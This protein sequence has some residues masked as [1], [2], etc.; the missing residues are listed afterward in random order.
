M[1]MSSDAIDAYSIAVLAGAPYAQLLSQSLITWPLVFVLFTLPAANLLINLGYVSGAG[2]VL[3]FARIAPI[4]SGIG[5]ALTWL[6]GERLFIRSLTAAQNLIYIVASMRRR[7]DW[8]TDCNHSYNDRLCTELFRINVSHG[9]AQHQSDNNWPAQQFNKYGVRQLPHYTNLS[10]WVPNAWYFED[11]NGFFRTTIALMDYSS[12]F[13]GILIYA[14]SR[15]RAGNMPMN[16]MALLTAQLLPPTFFYVLR[17]GCN[18]HLANVQPA[19]SSYAATACFA[20]ITGGPIWAV[21]YYTANLL[22]TCIGPMVIL[23]AFIY[24]SFVEQFAFVERFRT[25]LLALLS[26]VFAVTGW[27]SL[28]TDVRTMMNTGNNRSLLAFLLGAT[29]PLYTVLLFTSVPALLVA[30]LVSVFDLLMNGMDIEKHIDYGTAF[31]SSSKVLNRFF[32][33]LILLGPTAIIVIFAFVAFYVNVIVY[34]LPLGAI[35]D[36]TTDWISHA[37]IRQTTSPKPPPISH[38]ICTSFFNFSYRTALF[39]IFLAEILIGIIL[40]FLFFGNVFYI[41]FA[42]NSANIAAAGNFRTILFL[43]LL[44][45]H[46]LS[47][48]ELRWTLKR[49]DHSSRLTMY[50]AV[51]TTE[52]AF[53]NGYMWVAAVNHSWGLNYQPFLVIF[54]NTFLRGIMIA[55]VIAIRWNITEMSHPT[56]TRDAAEI[57]DATADLDNYGDHE[58][59]VPTIYEIRRDVFT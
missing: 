22:Y 36:A 51:A 42:S 26:F 4:A 58:D 8:A 7:L 17:D 9:K 31:I 3:T 25:L 48:I 23:L 5:W 16:A 39:V 52:M 10:N 43:V 54:F 29:S 6:A 35:I 2:P 32:G 33:Y 12:A 55:V 27:Y 13:T 15:I 56:R 47:L 14:S 38:H 53:L 21:I 44:T 11:P 30:K 46:I 20:T 34:R 41:R 57:Y 40:F 45:F 1:Y 28:E 19:Y 50:I 59:D 37:S 18:G 49:W 24:N